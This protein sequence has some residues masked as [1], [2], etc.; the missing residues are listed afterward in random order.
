LLEGLQPDEC[1]VLIEKGRKRNVAKGER[2]FLEGEP[3]TLF[4]ILLS[5]EVKLLQSTVDGQQVIIQYV[6]PGSGFGIIVVLSQSDYP[7]TAE[8]ADD[9]V[10]LSWDR[11]TTTAVMRQFPQL[12]L[13]GLEMVAGRF[14][15]LQLRLRELATERVEQRIAR[16]ILRLVRQFGKRVEAGVLIDMPLTHLD[17]AN[18]SGTTIYTVSRILRKWEQAGIITNG[19]LQLTLVHPHELVTI[20]EGNQT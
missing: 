17:I 12:A 14:M 19:R 2:F 10:A 20:A 13:N 15:K 8:A 3:A 7:V 6:S 9:C 5:G 18:M 1:A 4:Y 11:E 16:T